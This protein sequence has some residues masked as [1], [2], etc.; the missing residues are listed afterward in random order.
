MT[1]KKLYDEGIHI[2]VSNTG[3][4]KVD[5]HGVEIDLMPVWIEDDMLHIAGYT[6]MQIKENMF[7]PYSRLDFAGGHLWTFA[8]PETFLEHQYGPD[9]RTP[10]PSYF[11]KLSAKNFDNQRKLWPANEEMRLC[12]KSAKKKYGG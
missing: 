7:E 4:I 9:W 5:I 2:S 8:Q 12:L 6:S 3:H 11:Y 1:L 10:D